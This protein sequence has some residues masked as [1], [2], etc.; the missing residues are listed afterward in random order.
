ME[1]ER[2][3]KKYVAENFAWGAGKIVEAEVERESDTSVWI[4]GRRAAKKTEW[5]RYFDSWEEAHQY[6]LD[7]AASKVVHVRNELQRANDRL[8]NVKGMKKP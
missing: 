1:G 7:L 6:L 3:M 2:G 8:G 5:R 4:G